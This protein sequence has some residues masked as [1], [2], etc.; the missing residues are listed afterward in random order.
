MSDDKNNYSERC[1][2]HEEVVSKYIKHETGALIRYEIMIEAYK[3]A[4][5][6]LISSGAFKIDDG[7]NIII[8]WYNQNEPTKESDGAKIGVAAGATSVIAAVGAPVTAWTLVGAFG[9]ASTGA[10]ISGLSGAAATSATAAAFGGGSVATGGLGV[11]AAPFVLSGIGI[12]AGGAVLLTAATLVARKRN[13]SKKAR[14]THTKQM[15]EAERRLEANQRVLERIE[16]RSGDVGKRLIQRAAVLEAIK[17]DQAVNDLSTT[18]NDADDLIRECQEG[19]PYTRIYL[20]KPGKVVNIVEKR[21]TPSEISVAWL[22][23][24][25]GGSEISKYEIERRSGSY[26]S[27]FAQIKSTAEPKFTDTDVEPGKTYTYRIAAVNPIGRGEWSDHI[28]VE[29]PEVRGDTQG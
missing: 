8:G 1:D 4:Q 2:R 21:A 11:A 7:G 6:V 27:N 3:E 5:S 23:P 13:A 14:N 17:T 20:D 10:A 25:D 12:V 15:D 9:T 18:L 24:D 19:V 29:A 22:D 28:K 26:L 16:S